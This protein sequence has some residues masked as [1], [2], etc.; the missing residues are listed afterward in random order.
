MV[1]V[2]SNVPNIVSPEGFAP[3]W[4]ND[5]QW[6][7]FFRRSE[8]GI[9]IWRARATGSDASKIAD[10]SIIPPGYLATPYLKIGT[11]HLSWSRDDSQIAYIAKTED[12]T[13]I[14]IAAADG[15]RNA[16]ASSSVDPTDNVCCPHWTPDGTSIVYV[17]E[18]P[19]TEASEIG[20]SRLVSIDVSRP[21]SKIIFESEQRFRFLGFGPDAKT[22]LIAVRSDPRSASMIPDS[23]DIY[24]I[25]LQSGS[26]TK[27]NTLLNAYFHNIHLSYDGRSIAFVTRRDNISAIWNVP[28]KGGSPKQLV[29]END[30]KVLISGLAWS[31]AGDRI[32]FGRQT[33]TNMLSMLSN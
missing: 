4:S 22:A 14:W 5:G 28:V 10:G 16:A 1:T 17:S 33:R 15:S 6:I 18:L 26:K 11:G 27:V 9:S 25:S 21:T 32:V 12:R 23:T 24:E 30:P 20:K 31:H 2:G 3:E 13:N 7:A 8:A 19:K 29:A